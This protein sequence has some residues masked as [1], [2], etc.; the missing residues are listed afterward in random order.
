MEDHS[1]ALEKVTKLRWRAEEA[2]RREDLQRQED[3]ESMSSS[4]TQRVLHQLRVHQVELQMQNDELR[5]VLGE[6]EEAWA[7]YFDLF[8]L[9]PVGYFIVS[10]GGLI[11]EANQTSLTMLGLMEPTVVGQ[12]ITRFLFSEDQDIYTSAPETTTG[13]R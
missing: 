11:L 7:R 1:D 9:A 13:E 5:R 4:E 6:L 8:K 2:A 12:P 10:H 3:P